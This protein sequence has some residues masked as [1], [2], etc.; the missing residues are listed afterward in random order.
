M[1][2]RDDFPEVSII[3]PCLNEEAGV[4]SCVKKAMG[5]LRENNLS[6]EVIVVDNGSSDNS[7]QLAVEAGARLVVENARG[8]GRAYRAGIREA[9]GKYIVIGDSD[10]TY[11]FSQLMTFIGPL[12]RGY[13]FVNGS[14][15]KGKIHKGAMPFL[16]RYLG[17]PLLSFLL[18]L[19]F[20]S[21]FSDVYCGM[22]SFT[23][24]AYE[25]IKPVS[26]GME[27]ALELVI[28][29]ARSDLKRMEV[30]VD[31]S[32]RKGESKL[33]TFKDGWRSLRFMLLFS[34]NYMFLFPGAAVFTIGFLGMSVLLNGPV[35]FFNHIFDFH[36]MI[37]AGIMVLLGFQL[38]NL[39]F[40]AK[41]YALSEGF[42]KKDAFFIEFYKVFNLEKGIMSG[43]FLI[44]IGMS[45]IV[46]IIK[47][48]LFFGALSQERSEY[49]AL[50][51]I[52]LGVQVIFSS[53]LISLIGMKNSR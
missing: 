53:F 28:N 51:I 18:N 52:T 42:E 12:R 37:F 10:G 14:R 23:K 38:L 24:E 47:N 4:F 1:T 15:V 44:I 27:F 43:L 20:K 34:P 7:Q 50:I 45:F 49:F 48:W 26:P 35:K 22:K 31:L 40:F 25:S 5:A 41:S 29:A 6:G 2:R 9:K 36:A 33:R 46:S 30:P 32:P 3:M 16:H 39:G 11:D 13:L 17:N 8:Y 21:G 19:F